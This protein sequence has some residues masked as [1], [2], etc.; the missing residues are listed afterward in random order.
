[1]LTHKTKVIIKKHGNECTYCAKLTAARDVPVI[2]EHAS[3]II[4]NLNCKIQ[5]LI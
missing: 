5:L 4:N 1:M 2:E 3:V